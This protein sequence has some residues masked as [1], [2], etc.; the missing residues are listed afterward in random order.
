MFFLLLAAAAA[1][2]SLVATLEVTD[3]ASLIGGTLLQ[4]CVTIEYGVP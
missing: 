4:W 2:T 1:A 3:D